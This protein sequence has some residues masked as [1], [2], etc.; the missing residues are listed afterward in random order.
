MIEDRKDKRSRI[1]A[2]QQSTLINQRLQKNGQKD[3]EVK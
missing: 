1:E 2:T 3:M